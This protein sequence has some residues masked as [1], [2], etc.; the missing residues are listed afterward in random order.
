[1]VES[2]CKYCYTTPYG[3]IRCDRKSVYHVTDLYLPGVT[4][5]TCSEHLADAIEKLRADA[6]GGGEY[7][8]M[9]VRRIY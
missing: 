8:P 3:T 5:D 9:L 4:R 2:I 1:M 7:M 6:P